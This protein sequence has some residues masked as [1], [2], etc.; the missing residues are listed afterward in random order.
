MGRGPCQQI[1]VGIFAFDGQ[2]PKGYKLEVFRTAGPVIGC[3]SGGHLSPERRM[4]LL[5]ESHECKR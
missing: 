5:F 2:A 1:R 3:L 4:L